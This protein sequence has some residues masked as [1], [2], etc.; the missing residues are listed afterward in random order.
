MLSMLSGCVTEE[1]DVIQVMLGGTWIVY[2]FSLM[3]ISFFSRQKIKRQTIIRGLYIFVASSVIGPL[4]IL[5][6]RINTL[7][8]LIFG[9]F[10]VLLLIPLLLFYLVVIYYLVKITRLNAYFIVPYIIT[11]VYF[12]SLLLTHYTVVH[13]ISIWLWPLELK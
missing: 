11:C 3:I 7:L 2:I 12:V 10:A 1:E 9:P 4:L 6:G 5:H 13:A 8:A